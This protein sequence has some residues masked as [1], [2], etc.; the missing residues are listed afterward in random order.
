MNEGSS[1]DGSENWYRSEDGN[2][3]GDDNGEE[4]GERD[5]G[6]LPYHDKR[7]AEDQALP[8]CTPHHP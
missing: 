6:N 4:S 1:G 3:D 7:R 8:F 2:R 5:L